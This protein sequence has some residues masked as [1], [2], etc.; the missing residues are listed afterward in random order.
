MIWLKRAPGAL[1]GGLVG[2]RGAAAGV[3][4]GGELA[5][6]SYILLMSAARLTLE[7]LG[8]L[9]CGSMGVGNTGAGAPPPE[10]GARRLPRGTSFLVTERGMP[11][12]VP[13]PPPLRLLPCSRPCCSELPSKSA[14]RSAL[15][16]DCLRVYMARATPEKMQTATR[17]PMMAPVEPPDE[18]VVSPAP[19]AET[20]AS[21]T[22]LAL[23]ARLAGAA[24]AGLLL[25]GVPAGGTTDGLGERALGVLV[26]TLVG[27]L[28][29]LSVGARVG[30]LLGCL[31]GN[32][33][34][35]PEG[36]PVGALLGFCVTGAGVTGA[37]VTGF[38]VGALLGVRLGASVVGASVGASAGVMTGEGVGEMAEM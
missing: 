35:L 13:E 26:G 34:G 7:E 30:A 9:T 28:L 17:L 21:V 1:A 4:A 23:G 2:L 6:A 33:V 5:S 36:A 8:T 27:A 12:S 25:L 31:V 37:G 10:P 22:R 20:G 18:S 29:G 24:V 16:S 32:A 19:T 14:C 15:R 3:A 11:T 38:V